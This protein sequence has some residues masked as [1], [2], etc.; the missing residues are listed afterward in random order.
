[1]TSTVADLVLD[2]NYA[3]PHAAD[4]EYFAPGALPVAGAGAP[5]RVMR[6]GEEA[7]LDM[8]GLASR[9]RIDGGLIR[10]RVSQLAAPAYSGRFRITGTGEVYQLT[11]EPERLD[12]ARREWTCQTVLVDG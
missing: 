11:A 12:R 7:G 2:A 5:V 1:M 8:P 4:A 6:G 3:G 10:V 9:P